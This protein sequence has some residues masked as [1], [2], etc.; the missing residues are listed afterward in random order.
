MNKKDF[1]KI[2]AKELEGL[3]DA[4][5]ASRMDIADALGVC[6][7]FFSS[8]FRRAPLVYGMHS[9]RRL[10]IFLLAV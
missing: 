9:D 5:G 6:P 2:K 7:A 3:L 1:K 8:D 4:L 10:P